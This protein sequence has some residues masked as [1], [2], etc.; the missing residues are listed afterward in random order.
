[1]QSLPTSQ[2]A[3]PV[4]ISSLLKLA[5]VHSYF[6]LSSFYFSTVSDMGHTSSKS[7]VQ[8]PST[9]LLLLSCSFIMN[10]KHV[11][12]TPMSLRVIE[13]VFH[14][15]Y[16]FYTA[17][18]RMYFVLIPMFAWMLSAW[19]LLFVV[20]LNLFLVYDYDNLRWVEK[21]IAAMYH[22]EKDVENMG[23]SLLNKS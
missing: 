18:L 22:G 15:S 16:S 19:V 3:P 20:P 8:F 4:I 10:V 1:M 9:H 14:R 11:S 12:G 21:D 23:I 2:M 13:K 5:F 7:V 6:L 17:G